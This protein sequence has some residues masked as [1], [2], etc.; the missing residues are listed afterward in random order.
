[1]SRDT[2]NRTKTNAVIVI[3]MDKLDKLCG[4]DIKLPYRA[5]GWSFRATYMG[6]YFCQK[7]MGFLDNGTV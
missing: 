5:K 3:Y 6:F 7:N 4:H 2:P 1:M